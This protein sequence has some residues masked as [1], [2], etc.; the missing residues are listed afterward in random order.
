VG[1]K[2]HVLIHLVLRWLR[3]WKEIVLKKIVCAVFVTYLRRERKAEE[4][5]HSTI[6]IQQRETPSSEDLVAS[7]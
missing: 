7:K 2:E 3:R 1:K 6:F 4:K 5:R